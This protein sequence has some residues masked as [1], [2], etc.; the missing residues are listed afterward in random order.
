MKISAAVCE[1]N[2][3]H[4]GHKYLTDYA[5]SHGFDYFIGIMSGSVVQR[6]EFAI[7]DKFTR[8]QAAVSGGVDMII[9]LPC[10]YSLS[11]AERFA[12]GAVATLDLCGCIDTLFF[13]AECENITL[14][15]EAAKAASAK[16]AEDRIRELSANGYSHPR[17][18]CEAVREL[19]G[20]EIAEVLSKPNNTLAIEYIK[21]LN[22]L[23]SDVKPSAVLRQGA[24]HDCGEPKGSFAS[25]SLIR[26]M[27]R[28]GDDSY[29]LYIPEKVSE[30]IYRTTQKKE[31]PVTV[32]NNDRGFLQALRRLSKSEWECV[33]GVGEGLE[34]RLYGAVRECLSFDEIM[35]KVKCKRYTYARISRIL[36]CAYLGITKEI[37]KTE[38]QYIRV[39]AMNKRGAE[40]LSEISRH[41]RVPVITSPAKDISK[42][43]S[44]GRKLFELECLAT[45][46]YTLFMP[47]IK[48]CGR[49]YKS[50][51]IT[52][53]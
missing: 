6:G 1:Y 18:L 50:K 27:I 2:P 49:D 15:S 12:Y 31:C 35:D 28:S 46:M 16:A 13:G 43:D 9:E 23:R 51:L 11:S 5:R 20:D 36:L 47:D 40:V 17:A 53:G 30:I 25:A 37:I 44:E 34:N 48:E 52:E 3:Y 41:A 4:N 38:P 21:A 26:E 39:L 33:P 8:A 19:S 29:K 22:V 14:L 24:D 10:I 7:A 45:D 42:L 32:K